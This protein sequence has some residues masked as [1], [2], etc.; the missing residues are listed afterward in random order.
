MARQPAAASCVGGF[1]NFGIVA[2]L[3]R[4]HRS[5]RPERRIGFDPLM[6]V[7]RAPGYLAPA[8]HGTNGALNWR[9]GCRRKP[10]H[11]GFP[12][13]FCLRAAKSRPLMQVYRMAGTLSKRFSGRRDG[14][15]APGRRLRPPP[16]R[17]RAPARAFVYRMAGK[18]PGYGR[19]RSA[20]I[21]RIAVALYREMG[22]R[23][24]TPERA[25]DGKR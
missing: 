18:Q 16:P 9:H 4:A 17:G 8:A 7:L 25:D 13:R 1:R 15:S 6:T 3:R 12:H 10:I 11:H 14:F 19:R 5:E 21:H 23:D 20:V 2:A 22:Y 24:A